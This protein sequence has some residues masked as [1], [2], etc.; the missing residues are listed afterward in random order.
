MTEE[1]IPQ[2]TAPPPPEAV[3]A[4]ETPSAEIKGTNPPPPQEVMQLVVIKK[5][6]TSEG[7]STP[8]N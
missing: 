3:E 6:Q 8:K 4:D 2:G 1:N 7:D 5:G